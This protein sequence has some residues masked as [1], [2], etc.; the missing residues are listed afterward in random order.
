MIQ[1]SYVNNAD[2]KLIILS[3]LVNIRFENQ[4]GS[5]P[6]YLIYIQDQNALNIKY[7]ARQSFDRV[8]LIT[9]MYDHYYRLLL[10]HC[11]VS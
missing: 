1:H 7:W 2:E 11:N 3:K 6:G 9:D 10:S 4:G 8:E 5:P